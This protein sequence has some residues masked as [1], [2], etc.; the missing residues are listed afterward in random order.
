MEAQTVIVTPNTLTEAS[1]MIR[2]IGDPA[3]TEICQFFKAMIQVVTE[4]YHES[5][6]T[7]G[8]RAFIRLGLTDS[9]LLCASQGLRTLLTSDLDL[10]LE[11]TSLGVQAINFNHYRDAA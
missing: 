10:Y 2:Y 5:K 8:Q 9:V 11:A 3:R 4:E 6:D 7:A 1:N